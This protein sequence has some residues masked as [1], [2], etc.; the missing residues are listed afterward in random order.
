MDRTTQSLRMA[1]LAASAL[2]A[3]AAAPRPAA[4]ADD[5]AS[6]CSR[7][8]QF[9][10]TDY[11]NSEPADPG[12]T[13]HRN[14]ERMIEDPHDLDRGRALGPGDAARESLAVKTYEEGKVR[15][16]PTE[17]GASG[18]VLTPGSPAQGGSQ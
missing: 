18:L 14:L 7:W 10:G 5:G 3:I 4:A 15:F 17:G 1:A 6:D 16:A 12:C 8:A 2:V 9:T 11:Q 13:N